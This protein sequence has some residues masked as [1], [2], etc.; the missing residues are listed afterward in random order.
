MKTWLFI[1]LGIFTAGYAIVWGWSIFESRRKI[2]W[3]GW[4]ELFVGLVTNFFDTLGI[5]SYAPTTSFYKLWGLVPDEHIPGTMNI[6][7]TLPSV[8]EAF[9][10][11]TVVQVD[12]VTLALMIGASVVGAW[13]GAG[14]VARLPRRKV[15]IGMGVAL[16]VMAAFFLMSQ[17]H[18][19]PGGGEDLGLTGTKLG[20]AVAANMILGALMT[21]GIGMYAP[22]MMIVYLMGM[23]PRAA[24]PIMTGSCAFLMPAGSVRFVREDSYN[25]KAALGLLIG[26]IP[27]VMA[28]AF[29]VKE[30]PLYW[31]RWLVIVVV[32]YT[33]AMML[34]SAA[35]ERRRAAAVA[36]A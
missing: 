27:G 6:G 8:L 24:F 22:S 14:V 36:A 7:D 18:L 33:A 29:I 15:Q 2:Q 9:I 26:G 30:M 13:F 31:V 3:P 20:L 25:L 28:A 1:A 34:R 32:L 4:R 12:I 23:S 10:Y 5:G 17:F 21:L 11:I 35:V 16:L 19:G